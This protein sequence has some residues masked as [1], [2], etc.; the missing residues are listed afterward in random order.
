MRY[1]AFIDRPDHLPLIRSLFAESDESVIIALRFDPPKEWGDFNIIVWNDLSPSSVSELGVTADDRVI[2]STNNFDAFS[3]VIETLSA[4]KNPSSILILTEGSFR[5]KHKEKANV[6][7]LDLS[8]EDKAL[9]NHEWNRLETRRKARA[10]VELLSDG[11]KILIMTQ[12]D[13]DPDAIGCGLALQALL[14]R[15]RATAPICT[16]GKVTRSEN[17]TMIALLRTEIKTITPADV[18]NFDRIVMVDVAPP[19]FADK[20]PFDHVDAVIDHHPY[21]DENEADFTDIDVSCGATSTMLYEYLES[22]EV[23]ISGRVATALLYGVITDTMH[24]SRGA[25]DRD[26]RAYTNLW[27]VAQHQTLAAMSRPRLNKEE[28]DFFVRAIKSYTQI[29]EMTFVWLGSVKE[30]DIIPRIADFALQF[31]ES[32]WTAVAGIYEKELIISIRYTGAEDDAGMLASKLFSATGS[33]GGHKS[34]AKAVGP[35]ALFKKTE[36][37]KT[38]QQI[39]QR[40]I[41]KFA[42]VFE[43]TP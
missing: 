14:G 13:P 18:E 20:A 38:H 35:L 19:Y 15:N 31:D 41:E 33:A 9:V 6:S 21:P 22:S 24:L 8:A 17:R 39:K 40:L 34:M 27:P 1:F 32:S 7:E 12:D 10:L 4:S 37:V 42:V 28:L 23:N 43:N 30:P 16:F 5:F 26:F 36:N 2:I 3:D 25:S 11:R 29:G